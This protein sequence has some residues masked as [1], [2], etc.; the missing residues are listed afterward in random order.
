MDDKFL[1]KLDFESYGSVGEEGDVCWD[2]AAL[3]VLIVRSPWLLKFP[4]S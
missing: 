2:L 1:A 4:P 3:P